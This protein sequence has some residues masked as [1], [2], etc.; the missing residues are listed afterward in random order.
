VV[1]P[2]KV[3]QI[4]T[5]MKECIL[6]LGHS[7]ANFATKDSHQMETERNTIGGICN[8]DSTNAC[9]KVVANLIIDTVNL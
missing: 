9:L 7:N 8:R 2:S 4:I 1:N 5:C 3:A 6:G